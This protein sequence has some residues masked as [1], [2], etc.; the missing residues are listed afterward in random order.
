MSIA[1][2]DSRVVYRSASLQFLTLVFFAFGFAV[3]DI[4]WGI[5]ALL[6]GV[7]AWFSSLIFM[8]FIFYQCPDVATKGQIAW[9][10]AL[11]EMVKII[12]TIVLLMISLG[13]F[14]AVFLP[15]S[16]SYLAVW[17]VHIVTS[18]IIGYR[19]KT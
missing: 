12:S 5:S 8:L 3:K 4:S 11:S 10:L 7:S 14:K 2:Y 6:G 18:I 17:F 13:W 9:S 19:K 16:L 1:L 15:L